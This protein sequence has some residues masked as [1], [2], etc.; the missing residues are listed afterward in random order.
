MH[1]LE[2]RCIKTIRFLAVDM[3]ERAQSGHPGMPLGAAPM[4]YV[5]WGRFLKHNPANP[6]WPDRDRFV[7]SAGHGSALL[8]A[9]LHLTGYDVPLEELQRFRQW[10]S[11]TPGH[12]ERGLTPGI[13]ATTGPLGQGFAMGVGMAMAECF[14]AARFNRPGHAIV[15]HYTYALVSDGDLM[16]GV[17]SEAAS[18]AGTLR[19]GKLIYLYDDN[20][21]SIEGET[22]L[23][24]TEDVRRRFEAYG[25]QV[26]RVADGEDLEAI[27]AAIRAA[28]GETARPSLIMVRTHIGL[29]SPKQ[30]S[31]EARWPWPWR[32][33]RCPRSTRSAFPSP[34]ASPGGPMCWLTPTGESRTSSSSPPVRKCIWR[35]PSGS[36]WQRRGYAHG[37][38]L[39]HRG[40]CST[41]SPWRTADKCCR[42]RRRSWLLELIA[43]PG[44]KSAAAWHR[45]V[46]GGYG[47]GA[48]DGVRGHRSGRPGAGHH[49]GAHPAAALPRAGC[50]RRA[51]VG[52]D[53]PS[54]RRP[55]AEAG[56]QMMPSHQVEPH[57]FVVFGATG[58]LMR[59]KLLPALHRL[60]DRGFIHDQCVILGAARGAE[61]D[62]GFRRWAREALK[63]AGGSAAERQRW[64]DRRLHYQA[65]DDG[66]AEGYRGLA[67][68]L[69]TLEHAHELPGNRVFYLALPPAAFPATLRGLG[70]AGLSRGGG[71]RRARPLDAPGH[72]KALRPGSRLRPGA[73]SP[74]PHPHEPDIQG[75]LRV[76]NVHNVPLATNLATAEMVMARLTG[77]GSGEESL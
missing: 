56:G 28:Q 60:A 70:E 76:C 72:R 45:S 6:S 27:D 67:A 58:D 20:H 62:D 14:L 65:I 55:P 1:T 41:S 25:W 35:W 31:A 49:P 40:S 50:L 43:R 21:I 17:A 53:A 54:I 22:D 24:F 57:L 36:A 75:L 64:C 73:E 42:L 46:R 30:D 38:S 32:G 5:L 39:C 47:R 48:L 61:M 69:R 16:Q 7:L 71:G 74:G 11:K 29:D 44:G 19:L 4:A 77:G 23:A 8:Y 63:E 3:V 59:R 51:T 15:D 34:R 52:G 37:W 26:Q 33:R 18:L 9:L 66:A 12:P 10:G 2:Q 68:R 13:E